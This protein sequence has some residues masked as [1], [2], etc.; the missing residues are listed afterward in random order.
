MR[1]LLVDPTERLPVGI[2]NLLAD[3]NWTVDIA[4]DLVSAKAKV[5][6][7]GVDAVVVGRPAESSSD[8]VS[9]LQSVES[10]HIAAVMVGASSGDDV[11]AGSTIDLAADGIS[12][13]ELSW[14]LSTLTR[15]QDQFQSMER[16]LDHMHKLG[17]RITRHFRELDDEMRLASRLQRDFLPRDVEAIGPLKFSTLYRP[18]S[19]VSGDIFDIEKIDDKHVAFYI[20]DAVGH[21]VSAGLLTMFIK[22]SIV[23]QHVRSGVVTPLEPG[24]VLRK[25]NDA[26][27]QYT[28]PNCQFVTGAYC[29]V[30]IE[31]LEMQY[32]RGGHPYPILI[33]REGHAN[34]LEAEGG[35]MGLFGGME[36]PTQRIQLHP[37][38]KVILFTDG[39]E[40]AFEEWSAGG[41]QTFPGYRSVFENRADRSGAELVAFLGR[42]LDRREGSLMP[43]D[44]VTVLAV[45]VA[46]D[47]G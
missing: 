19:W 1:V 41:T 15:F 42:D 7:A 24:E 45:D 20:A 22:R 4:L 28:L 23:T 21:G 14:R 29:L 35:L 39:I 6:D 26:L 18:A 34:E 44:D 13:E 32:A 25:L 31:T 10:R 5:N 9:F 47:L 8:L 3:N 12:K 33:D 38:E 2:D 36:C 17:Q 11:D 30:N 40:A 46:A 16:E 37:G 43:A 27:A